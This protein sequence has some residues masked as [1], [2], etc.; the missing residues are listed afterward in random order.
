[1][2]RIL[3]IAIYLRENEKI[4]NK[5]GY[6]NS[7]QVV[8]IF[9]QHQYFNDKNANISRDIKNEPIIFLNVLCEFQVLKQ[10]KK[11]LHKEIP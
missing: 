10:T 3:A 8:H 2:I 9:E 5:F 6:L 1:M 7:N 11:N 4:L